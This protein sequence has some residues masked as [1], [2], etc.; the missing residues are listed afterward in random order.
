MQW[1]CSGGHFIRCMLLLLAALADQTAGSARLLAGTSNLS[2]HTAQPL[3]SLH[4]SVRV[5]T[6]TAVSEEDADSNYLAIC[7]VVKDQAA[8]EGS[9]AV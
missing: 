6:K 2:V 5:H 9:A 4:M 7:V 1:P 3:H 8:G